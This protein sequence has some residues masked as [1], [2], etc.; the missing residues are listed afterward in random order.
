MQC[1][2]AIL[3]YV[4]CP[5]LLYFSTLSNEGKI[6]GKKSLNIKCVFRFSLQLVSEAFLIL[7][8]IERDMI[9]VLIILVKF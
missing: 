1:A 5:A 2:C 3:Q 7:R 8:R 6:F 9:K 4:A